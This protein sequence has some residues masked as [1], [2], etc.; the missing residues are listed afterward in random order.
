MGTR[1][2]R[3]E[4]HNKDGVI[5]EKEYY[6]RG[7]PKDSKIT[8]YNAQE[9]KLKEVIPIQHGEKNGIY[10]SYFESGRV[11]ETGR[12]EHDQKIGIWTEYFDRKHRN[13]KKQIKYPNRAYLDE[14]PYLFREWD[15]NGKQIF[16]VTSK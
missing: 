4:T 15:E 10:M 3:W 1:H 5:L 13:R 8:W 7:H 14:E 16:S 6:F 12:Y 11:K 9:D 2:G